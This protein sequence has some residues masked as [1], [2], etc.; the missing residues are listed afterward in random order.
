M[1]EKIK[2]GAIAVFERYPLAKKVFITTDEQAFL[3]EDR[4]RLHDKD[5]TTVKRSE[6]IEEEKGDDTKKGDVKVKKSAEELISF[7]ATAETI[8]E[9]DEILEAGEKRATVVA[10]F[11]ARKEALTSKQD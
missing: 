8:A 9:L 11:N 4:A 10:A 2:A 1:N 3:S 7:A 6:V 5:F